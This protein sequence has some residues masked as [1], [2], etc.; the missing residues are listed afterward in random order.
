MQVDPNPSKSICDTKTTIILETQKM[1]FL[2]SK[3]QFDKQAN[4]D[5]ANQL[6][7]P[8]TRLP[9]QNPKAQSRKLAFY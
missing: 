8:S 7:Q 1:V 5:G 2:I 3:W 9:I 6:V 4:C